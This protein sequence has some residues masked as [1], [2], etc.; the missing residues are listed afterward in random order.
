MVLQ[1]DETSSLETLENFGCDLLTLGIA[2]IEEFGKVNE[3]QD[4]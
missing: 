4:N 1:V 3:L 2:S